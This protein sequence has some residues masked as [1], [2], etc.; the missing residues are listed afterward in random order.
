MSCVPLFEA[1]CDTEQHEAA[2]VER[3]WK[4]QQEFLAGLASLPFDDRAADFY[5]DVRA[6]LAARGEMIGPNDLLIAAIALV[7][8]VTLVTNNVAE[9][10]RVAGLRVED[11]EA[12]P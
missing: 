1:S 4:L 10:G 7:H 2:T 11:W 5:G 8:G 9:F 6:A 3:A 12:E